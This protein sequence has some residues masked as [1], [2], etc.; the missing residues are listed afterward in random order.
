VLFRSQKA[1]VRELGEALDAH[2]K[3]RQAEH[4]KL[5]LTGM[6]NVLEKLRSGEELIA[7]EKTLHAQGLVSV[8]KQLHD[9]LDAAVADAYGWPADLSDGDILAHLVDLNKERAAEEAAGHVRWLRPEY[10]CPEATEAKQGELLTTETAPAAK[11]AAKAVEKTD[12]PEALPEQVQ[13]VRSALATLG[14]PA[15]TDAVAACFKRMTKKRKARLEE[16]LDTLASLGQARQ[17]G[18]GLYLAA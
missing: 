12:W 17:T 10:Q 11:V 13:A 8:L 9:D 15:D 18:G 7:K 2:R 6:Y 4:E 14:V 16:L 5:T 3:A 1:R